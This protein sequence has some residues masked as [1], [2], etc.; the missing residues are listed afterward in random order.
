M[1]LSDVKGERTLDVIADIID[2]IA[3]IAQSE[4]AKEL[5]RRQALPEGMDKRT[6][7]TNR[8]RKALPVLLKTNKRDILSIMATI[9]G[10]PYAEFVEGINPM[11]FI[12]EVTDL[13]LDKAFIQL[14]M[15]AQTGEPSGSVLE[16]TTEH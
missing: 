16:N 10:K 6:F 7:L 1:K 9:A 11:S 14:F 2:P 15:P 5:F 3:N 8:V 4:A 12:E 13:L